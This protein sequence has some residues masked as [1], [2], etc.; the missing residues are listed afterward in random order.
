LHIDKKSSAMA[1]KTR[2]MSDCADR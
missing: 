2:H 1:L